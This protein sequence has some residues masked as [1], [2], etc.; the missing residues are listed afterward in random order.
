MQASEGHAP[1]VRELSTGADPNARDSNDW[2]A[3]VWAQAQ[4]PSAS[5]RAGTARRQWRR[6]HA[7]GEPR[8][9]AGAG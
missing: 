4:S 7:R 3:L 9:P 1:M 8:Q 2:S 6:R 5:S